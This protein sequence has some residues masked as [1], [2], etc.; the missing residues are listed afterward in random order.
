MELEKVMG[1]PN[2]LDDNLVALPHPDGAQAMLSK[3]DIVAHFTTPPYLFEELS[4]PRD[5][6][7]SGWV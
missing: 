5:P 1:D 7:G 6:Y 2:A 3:K 4:K